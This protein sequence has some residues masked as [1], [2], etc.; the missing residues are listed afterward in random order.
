MDQKTNL[1]KLYALVGDEMVKFW[2]ELMTSQPAKTLKEVIPK[3]ISPKG[4]ETET[5]I[6]M[7]K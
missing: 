4:I 7:L 6:E 2:K 5:E 3:L 1:N